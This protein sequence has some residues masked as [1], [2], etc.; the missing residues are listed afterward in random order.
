M[1]APAVAGTA[2]GSQVRQPVTA[3]DSETL[4]V[5]SL[6]IRCDSGLEFAGLKAR[7]VTAVRWEDTEAVTPR[8]Y[9]LDESP[10]GQ[11]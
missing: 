5:L 1:P 4:A 2:P 8:C 9:G 10:I 11:V 6:R 3:S 7:P